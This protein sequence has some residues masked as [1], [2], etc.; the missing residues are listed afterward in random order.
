MKVLLRSAVKPLGRAGDIVD[1]GDAYARNFLIPKGLAVAATTEVIAKHNAAQR[2]QAQATAKQQADLDRV[3]TQLTATPL[4]L[5]GKANPQGKLFAAIKTSDVLQAIEQQL[6]V[7]LPSVSM[8]PDHL[9][10]LG[11]HAVELQLD[12]QHR[13][14]VTIIIAHAH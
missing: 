9:K 4:R 5:S 11:S 6:K 12:A 13:V 14:S 7:H 10:T 1:A 2:H 8:K 3:M